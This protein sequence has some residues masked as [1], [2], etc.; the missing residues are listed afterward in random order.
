MSTI[1]RRACLGRSFSGAV[2]GVKI[3]VVTNDFPPRIG[4]INYYVDQIMR[5]LPTGAVT[6]EPPFCP[7]FEAP[8]V[9][10]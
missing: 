6:G 5:R 4:G 10:S 8:K 3:V 2:V 9:E 7:E 1:S